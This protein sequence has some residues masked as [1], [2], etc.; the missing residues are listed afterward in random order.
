M[1]EEVWQSAGFDGLDETESTARCAKIFADA[2]GGR[3][4]RSN[5]SAWTTFRTVVNERWSHGNVVLLG[6]AAH[7]AHFSIGSYQARRR[8][9]PRTR[10]LP[11][12]AALPPGGPRVRHEAAASRASPPPSERPRPAWSGSRTWTG[13]SACRPASSPSTSSPAAAGHRPEPAAARCRL[14]RRG[15]ARVRLPARHAP[16]VHPVPAAR[17]D[18]AQPRRRLPDGHVLGHRRRPR[19]LPPGPPR[20]PGARR[21]RPGDDPDGVRQRGGPHHPRLRGPLHRPAG[22]GVAADHRL[23]ARQRPRHRDR[24]AAG[25]QRPQGLDPA[26]VGG[27]GRTAARGQLAP[28]GALAAALPARQPDPARAVPGATDGRARAVQVRR[29]AGRPGPVSTCSSCTAPTVTCS[30]ASS[31]R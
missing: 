11:A 7:T 25:P 29:R 20:R 9:R 19:R 30:P 27:H 2:L 3:P 8:G 26:D 17:A 28:G 1:R 10:R 6:D 21:R 24:R 13:T 15:G 16:D 22:R 18:P 31:P 4:L 14:H 5:N 12:R 23:R